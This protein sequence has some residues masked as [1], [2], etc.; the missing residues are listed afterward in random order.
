MKNKYHIGCSGYYYPSWRKEFYPEDVPMKNWLQYY[1]TVFNTVEL[2][3]TFYRTPKLSDLKKYH[4]LTSGNFKF[5]VK[6]NKFIT[7]NKKLKDCSADI[8]AFEDLI[9]QGLEDKLGYFLFQMPPSF[10]F[11]EENLERVIE[12]VPHRPQSVIEFRHISWWTEEVQKALHKAKI[13]FCNVD[14]PGL[15]SWIINTTT[16]FYFRFHG[17]PDLF[18]SPYS[19]ARL[20]ELYRQ[21]PEKAVSYTAYFNN[22]YYG[23][24]YNNAKE[25]IQLTKKEPAHA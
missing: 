24:A 12:H 2:N 20:K 9:L 13:T 7:H 22:T 25:L 6:I 16:H 1:S 23:H 19:L 11:S 15:N 10:H 3:G 8:K 17:S 5:S 21:F 4:A 14:F 18:K